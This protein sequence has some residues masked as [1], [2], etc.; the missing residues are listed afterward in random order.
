VSDQEPHRHCGRDSAEGRIARVNRS[1]PH[2]NNIT[3]FIVRRQE[4]EKNSS[5]KIKRFLHADWSRQRSR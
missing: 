3:I 1:L 2:Y 5:K 4:F